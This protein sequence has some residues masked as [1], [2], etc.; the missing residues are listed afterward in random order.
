MARKLKQAGGV[1][2]DLVPDTKSIVTVRQLE[3]IAVRSQTGLKVRESSPDSRV[4]MMND[5]EYRR[6]QDRLLQRPRGGT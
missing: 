5:P 4:E 1:P 2:E 3:E 6:M